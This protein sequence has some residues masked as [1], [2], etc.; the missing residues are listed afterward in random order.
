[1]PRNSALFENNWISAGFIRSAKTIVTWRLFNP[2]TSLA[3]AG[4]ALYRWTNATTCLTWRQTAIWMT[5]LSPGKFGLTCL[6]FTYVCPR[7][8]IQDSRVY[9]LVSPAVGFLCNVEYCIR[10]LYKTTIILY[11]INSLG[12]NYPHTNNNPS[13]SKLNYISNPQW[14]EHWGIKYKYNPRYKASV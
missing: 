7:F 14:P 1:M 10:Q 13:S 11:N 9:F 5:I 2:D 12:Y 6:T 3:T 4:K 8:K